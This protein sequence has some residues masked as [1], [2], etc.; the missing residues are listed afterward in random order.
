M[1]S[2]HLPAIVFEIN[3]EPD[4][5]LLREK[6]NCNRQPRGSQVRLGRTLGWTGKCYIMSAY[7]LLILS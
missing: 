7:Y 2:K 3:E 1:N 6:F 4:Y 5:N